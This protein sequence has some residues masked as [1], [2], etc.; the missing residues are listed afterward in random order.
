M[1]LLRLRIADDPTLWESLGFAVSDGT[2]TIGGVEL[3]L[4]GS[5]AGS[6]I[7]GWTLEGDWPAEMDGIATLSG[8]AASAT[9]S[10]ASR[11]ASH[12]NHVTSID[13]LVVSTPDLDRT[14][15]ALLAAGLEL[16]RIREI[17]KGIR[18]DAQAGRRPQHRGQPADQLG[19]TGRSG[20]RR[21]LFAGNTYAG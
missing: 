8:A 10:T 2:C 14:I 9:P 18:R 13:H 21:R 16:R 15:E 12:P 3:E 19:H 5:S 11:P 20:R 1:T 4:A 17:G 7:V 6:G